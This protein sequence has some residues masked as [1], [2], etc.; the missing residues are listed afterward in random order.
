[1][2]DNPNPHEDRGL[3]D[4]LKAIPRP[5]P[6]AAMMGEF[7]TR[8][9]IDSAV[10]HSRRLRMLVAIAALLLL[11][12]G[13]AWWFKGAASAREFSATLK[14]ASAPSRVQAIAAIDSTGGANGRIIS[15]LTTALLT[16]SST[17]VRV[18]AAEALG[19]I[20]APSALRDA[21]ARSIERDS[22]PFV[23]AALLT[24]INRLPERDRAALLQALLART[25]LDPVLRAE[26]ERRS[27]S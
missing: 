11:A 5:A 22:S 1:M 14:A 16:D 13:G 15:A 24:A 10:A 26:A 27:K 7:H 8:A 3:L 6:P 23:Q 17:N 25:D 20:A 21:A 4:A 19:R 2:T 12:V 9:R 18:A